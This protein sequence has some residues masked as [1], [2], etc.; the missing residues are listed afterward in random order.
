[1]AQAEFWGPTDLGALAEVAPLLKLVRLLVLSKD[2]MVGRGDDGRRLVGV[3]SGKGEDEDA[4]SALYAT[5]KMEGI[6]TKRLTDFQVLVTPAES[7]ERRDGEVSTQ[8]CVATPAKPTRGTAL[9]AAHATP[10]TRSLA[11]PPPAQLLPQ[12]PLPTTTTAAPTPGGPATGSPSPAPTLTA[13][14][15][16]LGLALGNDRG[17]A[18]RR[19]ARGLADKRGGGTEHGG[20]ALLAGQEAGRGAV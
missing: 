14:M 12:P 1:M 6:A 8:G 5:T 9:G 13:G 7:E 11:P 17:V 19:N 4:P 2:C 20:K 15:A 3:A 16:R 18:A 10:H